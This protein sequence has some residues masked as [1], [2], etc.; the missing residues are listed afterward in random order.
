MTISFLTF[1]YI[2]E[3]R[4]I[5]VLSALLTLLCGCTHSFQSA[6][7]TINHTDADISSFE[8]EENTDADISSFVEEE[9]NMAEIENDGN[10]RLHINPEFSSEEIAF[11]ENCVKVCEI[12]PTYL[13]LEGDDKIFSE[14]DTG[15]MQ[16]VPDEASD[17]SRNDNTQ[18]DLSGNDNAEYVQSVSDEASDLSENDTEYVQSVLDDA[19]ELCET[20]L[21]F[22]Q[23]GELEK[24]IDTLNQAYLLVADISADDSDLMQRKEEVSFTISKRILEI[25]ASQN[26]VVSGES[27]AIPLVMN[28]YVQ[29]EIDFFMKSEGRKRAFIRYYKRSGRY[30]THIVAELEKAGLPAELSWLPLVESGFV[31]NA[32]SRAKA[33]GLWQFIPSTGTRFGLKRNRYVDERLD[34]EKSTRAAIAYLKELHHI[35]GDWTTALAAYNCGEGRVLRIIRKQKMS[36]VDNFWDMYDHLPRET[37]RYVPRFLATLHIVSNPEEY[38]LDLIAPLPPME[39]ETVAVSKRMHLRNIAKTIGLSRKI[40][41]GLNPELRHNIV[42]GRGYLLRVPPEKSDILLSKLKDIPASSP[43]PTFLYHKVKRG[44][45]L[46]SIAMRYRSSVK[47]IARA[48]KINKRRIIAG[49]IIKI[50]RKGTSATYRKSGKSGKHVVKKGD[51]LWNIA[52]RYG[53]TAKRIRVLNNMRNAKLRIRQV[54]KIPGRG[55][56]KK[57]KAAL[58]TYRVKRGDVPHKIAKRHNMPLEQFLRMNR[59]KRGSRIYPGQKLHVD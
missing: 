21:D 34:P 16:S 49:K 40:L 46:S 14:N 42:P 56:K 48:N 50:P 24:A 11:A 1:T 20:S 29:A 23:K 3:N 27:E 26:V 54:L 13:S 51:T 52:R 58:K 45:T 39:Y 25:Y 5:F 41:K 59:L 10:E 44:E 33:L 47:R 15:Y 30:R 9:E 57:R 8:E 12:S 22:W 7:E 31:T 43:P 6:I 37:A 35:F 55:Y 19:S 53:T 17:L 32:L 2:R 36:Y 38:G 4:K 28:S 18:S